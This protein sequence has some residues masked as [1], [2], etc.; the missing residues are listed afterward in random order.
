VLAKSTV[1]LQLAAL[2]VSGGQTTK[3]KLFTVVSFLVFSRP[4]TLRSSRR[5]TK[6]SVPLD[7]A[8]PT[9][10]IRPKNITHDRS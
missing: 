10:G 9:D 8:G 1:D 5:L 4:A 2:D 7:L 6:Q 3:L